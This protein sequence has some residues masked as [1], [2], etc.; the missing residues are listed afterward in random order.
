[1]EEQCLTQY[2]GFGPYE[3]IFHTIFFTA[4]DYCQMTINKCLSYYLIFFSL[5][6]KEGYEF[7][8]SNY[9]SY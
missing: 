4:S 7:V 1:M 5:F 2:F 6:L 9:F 3:C 8:G